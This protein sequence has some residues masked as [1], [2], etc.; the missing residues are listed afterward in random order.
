MQ[1]E[2]FCF[3][4]CFF[5]SFWYCFCNLTQEFIFGKLYLDKAD[6]TSEGKNHK[7]YVHKSLPESKILKGQNKVRLH[8]KYF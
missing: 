1:L 6:R 8:M 7:L 5:D 2:E 3:T 4:C